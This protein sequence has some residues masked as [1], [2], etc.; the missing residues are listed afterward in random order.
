MKHWKVIPTGCV[1]QV[2]PTAALFQEA[3]TIPL[4]YGPSA[5]RERAGPKR[6]RD[7]TMNTEG[8]TGAGVRLSSP[9]GRSHCFRK[10]T[11]QLRYGPKEGGGYNHE[12]LKVIPTGEYPPSP[13]GRP[14]CFRKL[15]NNTIKI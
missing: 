11:I 13:S 4:R 15:D 12:T 2:L 10:L 8:H 5:S 6:R 9:S 14:H 7:I 1:P 3:M